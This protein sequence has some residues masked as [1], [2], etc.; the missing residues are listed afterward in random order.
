MHQS[1]KTS[2]WDNHNHSECLWKRDDLRNACYQFKWHAAQ[3]FYFVSADQD[4]TFKWCK[5][6]LHVGGSIFWWTAHLS[7]IYTFRAQNCHLPVFSEKQ[8]QDISNLV[9]AVLIIKMFTLE[10]TNPKDVILECL[11]IG[12]ISDIQSYV[13]WIFYRRWTQVDL[14]KQ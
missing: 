10:L 14:N 12:N 6:K 13:K 7:L 3:A 9:E 2:R 5:R 1:W 4:I 8:W 11:F